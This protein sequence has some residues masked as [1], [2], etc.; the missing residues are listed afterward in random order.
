M[1]RTLTTLVFACTVGWTVAAHA[2]GLPTGPGREL[3]TT[4]CTTCH[5]LNTVVSYRAGRPGWKEVVDNMVLQGAQVLPEESPTLIDYLAT[6]LGPGSPPL[7]LTP[8]APRPG[9]APAPGPARPAATLPAGPGKELVETKCSICHTIERTISI[10][11]TSEEWN[12]ALDEM[13]KVGLQITADERRAILTYLNAQ[14][15]KPVPP[16]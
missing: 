1:K 15:G 7:T 6:H 9:A 8:A 5:N 3:L 10:R 11:R 14:F 13:A 4:A 12:H 16:R 2:Q